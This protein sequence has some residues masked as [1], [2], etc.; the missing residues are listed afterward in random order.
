M[1]V[2]FIPD[3]RKGNPYQKL[4]SEALS[5]E[6]VNVN[7]GTMFR[8][9]SASKSCRGCWKPDILHIHWLSPFLLVSSR[10]KT[11]L[12]SISFISELLI[13][14]AFG[15]KIVWTVHNITSHEKK[16]RS[17]EL[18]F[19]KILSRLCDKIIVHSLSAK[20]KV[21]KVYGIS[22]NSLVVVI[23]HGNYIN[24]YK[25]V[26]NKLKAR[27]QL[28]IDMED[29]VYLCFGK[30]KPYKGILELIDT[31]KKLKQMKI[32]LLLAG[33][34]VNDETGNEIREKCNMDKNIKIIFDLVPDDEIQVYMN[35]ADIVVLPYRDILTSGAV[36]LAMSFSKPVIAPA[37]GCIP[38]I[39]DNGG[40]LL[41]NPLEK[42]GLLKAM[43]RALDIGLKKIGKHNFELA[44]QLQWNDIAKKT[45][46][47]YQECL[48][49]KINGRRKSKSKRY[50]SN[51]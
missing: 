20:K 19:T 12:K 14:K 17:I 5:N 33:K 36:I 30:I 49:K 44:K 28:K 48:K 31:F 13:L 29:L 34:P 41:Y 25:N 21:M 23:P 42:D 8:L 6:G 47:V 35:A 16:H 11:V 43:K 46:E 39:L 40:N 26:V 4:L 1:K 38:D 10:K 45:Y 24:S 32:K 51:I 50:Y 9:F 15:V 2:V 27:N 22:R 3:E 18:F 37:M 7:F